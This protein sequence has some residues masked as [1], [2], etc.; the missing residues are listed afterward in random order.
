MVSPVVISPSFLT[1]SPLSLSLCLCLYQVCAALLPVCS[2][3]A[4]RIAVGRISQAR[5]VGVVHLVHLSIFRPQ[6]LG[7]VDER[8]AWREASRVRAEERR[9][10]FVTLPYCLV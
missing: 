5:C 1:S 9:T 6:F 4:E 7:E 8:G 2:R 10:C 3:I